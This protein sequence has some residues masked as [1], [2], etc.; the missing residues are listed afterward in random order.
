VGILGSDITVER[1]ERRPSLER[2]WRW[3][4]GRR[5]SFASPRERGSRAGEKFMGSIKPDNSPGAL[6]RDNDE[7][8][9]FCSLKKKRKKY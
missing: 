2:Y 3:S 9:G 6:Q 1:E 8:I 5:R 7:M 4:T